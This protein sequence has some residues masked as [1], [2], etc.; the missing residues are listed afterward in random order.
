MP[1]VIFLFSPIVQLIFLFETYLIY[2]ICEGCFARNFM[3]CF[4][5]GVLVWPW[6]LPT[7]TICIHLRCSYWLL[8][9]QLDL[10]P[11]PWANICCHVHISG[12]QHMRQLHGQKIRLNRVGRCAV[13]SNFSC[14]SV[15]LK[16]HPLSYWLW[17]STGFLCATL[18]RPWLG[19]GNVSQGC[20]GSTIFGGPGMVWYACVRFGSRED[21]CLY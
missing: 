21:W 1:I 15:L 17:T 18:H 20:P 5:Q 14:H 8:M 12:I 9:W 16:M 13:S 11:K 6:C 3:A 10:P 19:S 4:W 2:L 7:M